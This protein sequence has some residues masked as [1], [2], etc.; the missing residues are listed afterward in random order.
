MVLRYQRVRQTIESDVRVDI[1][2]LMR[3][4]EAYYLSKFTCGDKMVES[5][6]EAPRKMFRELVESHH[7]QITAASKRSC[8]VS[9]D[10]Y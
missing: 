7:I 5:V 8:L 10:M 2:N 9:V 3:L 1:R 6:K 4:R